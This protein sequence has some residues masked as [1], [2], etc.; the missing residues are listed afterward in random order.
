MFHLWVARIRRNPVFALVVLV[1]VLI[2]VMTM[3]GYSPALFFSDS[4]GYL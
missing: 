3:I 1:A 2:R 4:W